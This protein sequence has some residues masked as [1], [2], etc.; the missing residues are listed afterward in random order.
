MDARKSLFPCTKYIETQ[1]NFK[2]LDEV[3]KNVSEKALILRTVML[4]RTPEGK[5]YIIFEK[6]RP[7]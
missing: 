6:S 3:L 5:K 1:G 2:T 4:N 7:I